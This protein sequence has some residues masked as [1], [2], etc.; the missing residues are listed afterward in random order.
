MREFIMARRRSREKAGSLDPWASIRVVLSA[1]ITAIYRDARRKV[2]TIM[3]S[4]AVCP[5]SGGDFTPGDEF[6]AQVT[7]K[8]PS[9]ENS[10]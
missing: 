8:S 10:T 4:V 2:V 9:G 6:S 7:A 5:I 3:K 1:V